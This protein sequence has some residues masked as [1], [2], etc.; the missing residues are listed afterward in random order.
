M[1]DTSNAKSDSAN[2]ENSHVSPAKIS[3]PLKPVQVFLLYFFSLSF[4]SCYFYYRQARDLNNLQSESKL[5]PWLW[6]FSPLVGITLPFS[7]GTMMELYQKAGKKENLALRNVGSSLGSGLFIVMVVSG[8]AEK[9]SGGEMLFTF[10]LPLLAASLLAAFLCKEIN[11]FKRILPPEKLNGKA[12][13][14]P[15]ATLG[16]VFVTGLFV[17]ALVGVIVYDAIGKWNRIALEP[18]VKYSPPEISFS[19]NPGQ[20][21]WGVAETGTYSDGSAVLELAWGHSIS[22]AVFDQSESDIWAISDFRRESIKA[23]DENASCT[24]EHYIRENTMLRVTDLKCNLKN[25]GDPVEIQSRTFDDGN[26]LV[27][28]YV[29]IAGVPKISNEDRSHVLSL[30]NSFEFKEI[31]N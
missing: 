21:G 26:Q 9:F 11:E 10:L 13:K 28:F 29:T 1:T 4:Y 14:V 20:G 17:T 23:D 24:E 6:F 8:V 5:K 15:L 3:P 27:E 12:Y 7:T 16:V 2:L 30:L 19:L 18:S 31:S 25:L 22:I